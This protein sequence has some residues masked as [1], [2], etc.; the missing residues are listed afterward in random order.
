M[1]KVTLIVLLLS[2]IFLGSCRKENTNNDCSSLKTGI[3]ADDISEVKKAVTSFINGLPNKG[4]SESNIQLLS[5]HLSSSCNVTVESTCF[6]CIKTLP[7]R[8]EIRIAV[9]TGG[10]TIAKTIDLSYTRANKIVFHN[11][12]D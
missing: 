3:Q 1:Q 9:T 10:V 6:D 5:Q 8:T 11:M 4:Y 2:T 12:H 7:S